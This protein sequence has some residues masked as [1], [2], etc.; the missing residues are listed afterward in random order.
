MATIAV[1]GTGLL[2]SGFVENLL[3]LGHRVR[4]WNRTVDKCDPL[5]A[6]GAIVGADPA[7]TVA[8]ADRVH[9]VL[10][11]DSAV[12]EVIEALRPGLGARVPVLDHSTNSP[13]GVEARSVALRRAGVRYLHAPVYMRP[14]DA[15]QATGMMFISGPFSEIESLR[16]ELEQ[17]TGRL[18]NLGSRPE[19][20]A[21][22]KL[23]LNGMLL[24]LAGTM[25]DLFRLV[26]ANG[27]PP[28]DLVALL[29]AFCPTA[30]V[31]GRRVM[32]APTQAASFEL[33]MARKDVG[34]MIDAAGDQ[35]D[36]ILLPS[37]ATAMDRALAEGQGKHDYGIFATPRDEPR[38]PVGPR[39]E[40][41][42]ATD[43]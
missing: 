30:P 43:A 8:G 15:R 14:V 9:L 18:N 20:A 26:Q 17:M 1:L 34:L 27:M 12:D 40:G 42:T 22:V 2:G 11:E 38:P 3:R 36:L 6:M 16:P 5:A 37:L 32:S 24:L 39:A 25:G 31:V 21:V 23:A 19:K 10:S 13:D 29:E 4:I 7:R 35:A 28:E 33:A 41:L